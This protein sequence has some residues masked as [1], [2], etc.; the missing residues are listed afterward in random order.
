MMRLYFLGM[1]MVSSTAWGM[2]PPIDEMKSTEEVVSTVKVSRAEQSSAL[3]KLIELRFQHRKALEAAL[4]KGDL[5]AAG[6]H[7]G[8]MLAT[9]PGD[10]TQLERDIKIYYLKATQEKES[11]T[12][13]GF[14][15]PR[16]RKATKR[17]GF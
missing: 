6:L 4:N 15:S 8:H 10:K 3:A 2:L 7:A 17:P 1:C 13:S 16:K 11:Q 14:K 5:N 12:A 9:C